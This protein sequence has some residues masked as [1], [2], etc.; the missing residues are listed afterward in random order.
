MDYDPNKPFNF[1]D[2]P[3]LKAQVDAIV[4]N[5]TSQMITVVSTAS[6]NQ[7]LFACQ[8]NDAF[9]ESILQT[10]KLK[11]SRLQ[12]YQDRNLDALKTFQTRKVDGMDLSKRVWKY[13]R[14]FKDQIEVG[15]DAG[16]GEGRSAQQLS[17]DVRQNLQEPNRLF[18]RVR[19]KRGNLQLS[20]AAQSFHP[21]QG[22]YRSSY[23][24]AMRLTRSEINMAYRQSDWMRWQN[25]D[26][27]AGYEI[28]RSNHEP[29]CKCEICE[30]L[31]GIYPKWFKFVGWHPQCLCYCTAILQ[32]EK[33]FNDKEAADLKAAFRGTAKK[34]MQPSNTVRD[35]PQQFKDWV[36]AHVDAQDGWSSTPYFIKDN[37]KDGLLRNGLKQTPIAAVEEIAPIEP[38]TTIQPK[39]QAPSKLDNITN[40]LEKAKVDY[41]DVMDLPKELSEQDIIARIGGGDLTKGSCSSLAFTYAGNKCGFDVLDFRNGES[42]Q[43]FASNSIIMDVADKVGGIVFEN[44]NDFSNATAL[45]KNVVDGK[46]YYFT[47][48]SH[49][50]IVRKTTTGFEYLELQSTTR[51]G[52]H[53]LTQ[54][55]LK[56]RFG[57]KKSHTMYGTKYK[58]KECLIDIDLLKQETGFRKMLGYINTKES[59]QMKGKSGTIK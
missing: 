11:K 55:E 53:P 45:L 42:R 21:G 29:Q 56:W 44:L 41:N 39:Q 13:T 19:D 52:F 5:L 22:V 30:S 24:N 12:K 8:K 2:Y 4:T 59:A 16:L 31:Q 18:R 36:D 43:K 7:W 3:R 40:T 54:Y 23:K 10:S 34:Q 51:N 57:A 32:S 35:V 26:F 46:E 50:A 27:V 9:L 14:Q 6:R 33:E 49:A 17:R 25:L 38:S 15:L 20:K 58:T 47:C 48:G 1:D 28:H 37:F